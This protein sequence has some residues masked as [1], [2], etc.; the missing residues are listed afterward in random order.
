MGT[1]MKALKVHEAQEFTRDGDVH[2]SMIIGT[3]RP[4]KIGDK[5]KALTTL[6]W[7]KQIWPDANIKGQYTLTANNDGPILFKND[8]F[9]IYA[10]E[11][12]PQ[13]MAMIYVNI[14]KTERNAKATDWTTFHL[15]WFKESK[16]LFDRL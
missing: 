15:D 7:D 11:D 6:Y 12:N 1:G 13:Y 8:T 14:Y 16:D 5:F 2:K 9:E 3:N 4:Y 10:I